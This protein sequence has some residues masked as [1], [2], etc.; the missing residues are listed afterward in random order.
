M[1]CNNNQYDKNLLYV[2][3]MSQK[4]PSNDKG[5]SLGVKQRSFCLVTNEDGDK[6]QWERSHLKK[7]KKKQLESETFPSVI[8]LTTFS[9]MNM[10]DFHVA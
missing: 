1:D 10:Y 3:L 2:I 5:K 8:Q 9:Q 4:A 7:K 6:R